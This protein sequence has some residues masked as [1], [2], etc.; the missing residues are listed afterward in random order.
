MRVSSETLLALGIAAHKEEAVMRVSIERLLA[1]R[2]AAHDEEEAAVIRV[3][4]ET[5]RP[6]RQCKLQ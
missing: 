2:V 3:S 5:L 4:R 6:S 1:L